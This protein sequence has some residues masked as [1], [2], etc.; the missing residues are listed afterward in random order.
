[1]FFDTDGII[2]NRYVPQGQNVIQH[3]Y[4][5]VVQHLRE[6]VRL[7][8]PGKWRNDNWLLHHDNA[9]THATLSVQ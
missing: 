1:M 7:K 2:H 6:A 4:K 8:R 9:P 5:G 3:F